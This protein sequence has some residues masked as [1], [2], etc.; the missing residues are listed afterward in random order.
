MMSGMIIGVGFFALPY[1]AAN[2]GLWT[3]L[4]YLAVLTAVVIIVHQYYAEVALRTP[5]FLRLPSYVGIYLGKKAKAVALFISVIGFL[6]TLLAYIVIGG[7]FLSGLLSPF[8]GGSQFSYSFAYFAAG[9]LIVFF[10]VRAVSKMEFLDAVLFVI[11]LAAVFIFGWK[12]FNAE[13]LFIGRLT[14]NNFFL[15]YGAV[16]FALWGGANI[17]S[18]VEEI[19]APDK[20]ALKK[21]VAWSIILPAIF[22]LF[23][24]LAALG[25][26]GGAVSSEAI[27]GLKNFLPTGVMVLLFIFGLVATFTSYIALSLILRNVLRYD[28][29]IQKKLAWAIA[30]FTPFLL[31][32]AGL[33]DFIKI[34]GFVGAITL[35]IKGVLIILMYRKVK[36]EKTNFL[37]LALILFLVLGIVYEVYY[38]VK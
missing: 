37:P 17:I 16:L 38:F 20:R 21:V 7:N 18:E 29:K 26:S 2:V 11:I 10:G 12:N 3:V 23:F 15:P 1:I 27:A 35:A 6:G 14:A 32:S 4:A 36:G 5:D 24:I 13:N 25:I 33:K 31:Y 30:C 34:I 22:Y 9:S 28:L 8:I 19:L